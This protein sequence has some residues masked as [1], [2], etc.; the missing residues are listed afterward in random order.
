[1]AGMLTSQTDRE[2]ASDDAE[3]CRIES[4]E[5]FATAPS[6]FL[7]RRIIFS[8][9]DSCQGN[10]DLWLED[11]TYRCRDNVIFICASRADSYQHQTSSQRSRAFCRARPQRK[12]RQVRRASSFREQGVPEPPADV[13]VQDGQYASQTHA[14]GR[15]V[16][17]DGLWIGY[18]SEHAP[19]CE[20]IRVDS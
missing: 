3:W 14:D 10:R 13:E 5:L 9:M 19:F 11:V 18:R 8:K 16:D 12:R 4:E 17:A 2:M 15:R 1:M 20:H 7:G 6:L